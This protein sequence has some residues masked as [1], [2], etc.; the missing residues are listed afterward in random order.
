MV[1]PA[2][3]SI[4]D[5]FHIQSDFLLQLTL[6]S[7][8]LA[9]AVAPLFLGPLSEIYGRAL[10]LQLSNLFYLAFNIGCGFSQN[11]GELIAFRFLSG[12]GASVPLVVS[13]TMYLYKGSHVDDKPR[14]AGESLG[15]HFVLK[16]AGQLVL[17]SA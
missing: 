4:R 2:L 7:F 14:L 9:Y 16:N 5:D 13:L 6:S 17:S 11:T 12:L 10:V 1:A 3:Q 15:I 8:I